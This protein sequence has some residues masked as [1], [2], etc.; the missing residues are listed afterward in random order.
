MSYI[1]RFG[2]YDGLKASGIDMR[3]D[4]ESQHIR[5]YLHKNRLSFSHLAEELRAFD[6]GSPKNWMLLGNA[7][8]ILVSDVI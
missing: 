8:T 6:A 4:K 3:Q 1:S 2:G 7:L 5:K